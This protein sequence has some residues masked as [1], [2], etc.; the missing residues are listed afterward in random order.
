MANLK[1]LIISVCIFFTVSISNEQETSPMIKGSVHIS[2]EKGTMSCDLTLSNLP[3]ADKY[4]IR[5][6]AGM[7]IHYFKDLK[8]GSNALYYDVDNSDSV[9]TD[10]TKSYY[11]HES[12]GNPARY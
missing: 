12:R 11:V 2:V 3:R 10:E 9:Q 8:R 1:S 6:N 5:L 4:V 7:N